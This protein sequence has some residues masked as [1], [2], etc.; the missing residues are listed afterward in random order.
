M[1]K[2]VNFS[3]LDLNIKLLDS[4]L[5]ILFSI[6]LIES[7]LM[8]KLKLLAMDWNLDCLQRKK[9]NFVYCYSSIE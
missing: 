3:L 5:T 9:I 2:I 7:Y 8:K 6:I 1:F 4:T